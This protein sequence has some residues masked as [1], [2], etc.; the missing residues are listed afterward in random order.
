MKTVHGGTGRAL[1]QGPSPRPINRVS[2]W[3][4]GALLAVAVLLIWTASASAAV[5]N[6]GPFTALFSGGSV[7]LGQLAG[8]SIDPAQPVVLS[9][10]IDADGNVVVPAGQAS[11]PDF[12]VAADIPNIGTL[13]GSVA[14]AATEDLTGSLDPETGQAQLNA[15]LSASIGLTFTSS[16]PLLPSYTGMCSAGPMALA[17]TTDSPYG[18]LYSQSDGSLTLSGP[19]S[20]P[21]F[22]GSCAPA[23]PAALALVADYLSGDGR[24][25]LSGA[26]APVLLAPGAPA[27]NTGE[28]TVTATVG[29]PVLTIG[30]PSSISFPTLYPG[31]TSSPVAAP[32]TVTSNNGFGYQLT[33]ERTEFSGGDIPLSIASDPPPDPG[34]VLDLVGLTPIPPAASEM[35]Q[36]IIGHRSGS[37]TGPDGDV[38]STS[39][40]LGPVPNVAPGQH[41]ATLTYTAVGF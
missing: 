33:V 41:T 3:A 2:R 21:S 11:I 19:V 8:I 38:W 35:D 34:M 22:T 18:V 12:P 4:V 27:P 31:Q 28:Q 5:A 13:S 40:V 36:V 17:L 7:Q 32:V 10:S 9:S 15:Q 26:L 1:E 39:L 24:I 20:V 6:P 16:N 37:M 14:L 30:V 23:L 29:A 25:T